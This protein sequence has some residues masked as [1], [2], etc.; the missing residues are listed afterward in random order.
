MQV[1]GGDL[2]TM[3]PGFQLNRFCL[4]YLPLLDPIIVVGSAYHSLHISLGTKK[5]C[6]LS[7]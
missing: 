4:E 5:Y 3:S 2:D 6:N 1:V 7:F